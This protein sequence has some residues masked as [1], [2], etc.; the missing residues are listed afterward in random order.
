MKELRFYIPALALLAMLGSC[1]TDDTASDEAE[2]NS[3]QQQQL[4]IGFSPYLGRAAATR[5]SIYTSDNLGTDGIGIYAMYTKDKMYSPTE[6]EMTTPAEFQLE[7]K[8]YEASPN[9][10]PNFMNNIK[11]YYDSDLGVW[12]YQPIRYWPMYQNEFITFLAYGPYESTAP[13]LY[14]KTVT[15]TTTE[16]GD[17][18]T[19]TTENTSFTEGGAIPIY[20]KYVVDKAP[21]NH[22]DIVWNYNPTWNMQSYPI[23]FNEDGTYNSMFFNW[24]GSSHLTQYYGGNVWT[25]LDNETYP[26]GTYY[27][28]KFKMAHACA[29]IAYSITSP[30]L[31]NAD[32]FAGSDKESNTQIKINK[33][34]FLGDA[35]SGADENPKGAF[36]GAGYFNIASD[37]HEDL[38]Q[39]GTETRGTAQWE[40]ID[41]ENKVAFTFT[42]FYDGT[43][44]NTK[45]PNIWVPGTS[46]TTNNILKSTKDDNGNITV[47]SI[48]NA[49]NGYLFVI[50]QDLSLGT[51]DVSSFLSGTTYEGKPLYL[52]IDYTVQYKDI[53]TGDVKDGVTYRSYGFISQNFEA[54]KSYVIHIQIGQP[55]GGSASY[56]TTQLNAIHF[57]V[58]TDSWDNEQEV[59][60]SD[61]GLNSGGLITTETL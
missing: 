51:D 41:S 40:G 57:N 50:P 27:G 4:E 54:G 26:Y 3:Q 47:N 37:S 23:Y 32:N 18:T 10:T 42:D 35:K 53:T 22:K 1:S 16:N 45:T 8:T 36:Y 46:T 38:N 29:R 58:T 20:K 19:T 28:V 15:T 52:Y 12:T 5:A 11:L 25:P 31:E 49:S 56:P 48:G 7:Q 61:F 43:Y 60:S 21:K 55:D 34:V 6:T 39:S 17:G 30:A 13:T 24:H 14:T 33:L 2:L 44:D 59:S 9:F